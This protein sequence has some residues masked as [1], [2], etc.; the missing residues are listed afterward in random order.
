MY[1]DQLLVGSSYT[2][3][4][5]HDNALATHYTAA[6]YSRL[7]NQVHNSPFY[8]CREIKLIQ[9]FFNPFYS[10]QESNSE[11]AFSIPIFGVPYY[12]LLKK[13]PT[14]FQKQCS[15]KPKTELVR[16]SSG[17]RMVK[18]SLIPIPNGPLY[19]SASLS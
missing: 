2:I 12:G 5:Y 4:S 16:L 8:V 17:F 19:I 3:T 13:T 9:M 6:L 15:G 14:T 10:C 18:S 11:C 7:S 1:S